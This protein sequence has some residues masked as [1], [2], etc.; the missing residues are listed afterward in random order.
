MCAA[1]L[2]FDD[3]DGNGKSR[4]TFIDFNFGIDDWFCQRYDELRLGR[5]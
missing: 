3:D 2:G 5:G 1:D 4:H